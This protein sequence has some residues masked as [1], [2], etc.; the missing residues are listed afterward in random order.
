MGW[1]EEI[2]ARAEAAT[3]GPWEDG[4]D[5]IGVNTVFSTHPDS[6]HV[7]H[8]S[9]AV[10]DGD[11]DGAVVSR[12]DATFIASARTDV[13]RLCSLVE[14]ADALAE[15]RQ[16]CDRCYEC[17]DGPCCSECDYPAALTRYT[18]ARGAK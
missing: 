14:L 10:I 3:P 1:L 18:E 13:P 5:G 17:G 16:H 8:H 15:S 12:T 4:Q 7:G 9:R 6:D 2:K 11:E